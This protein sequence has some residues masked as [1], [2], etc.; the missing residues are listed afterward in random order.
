MQFQISKATIP[1]L[2]GGQKGAV[3]V[4]EPTK[5]SGHCNM[6]RAKDRVPHDNI[7]SVC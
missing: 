2:D 3:F 1:A 5:W 6:Q 7:V 4:V